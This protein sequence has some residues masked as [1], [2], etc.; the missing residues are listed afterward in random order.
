MNDHGIAYVNQPQIDSRAN[1]FFLLNTLARHAQER[2]NAFKRGSG[3][4]V[5]D[6]QSY[7]DFASSDGLSNS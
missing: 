7:V 4:P 2:A 6:E 3:N 5:T 1:L